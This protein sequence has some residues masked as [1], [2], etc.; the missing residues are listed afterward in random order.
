MLLFLSRCFVFG[1]RFCLV[2]C[3][4][5]SSAMPSKTH[6]VYLF[7]RHFVVL[8][9]VLLCS[10]KM[11]PLLI[12]QKEN[13]I[14]LG[15]TKHDLPAV[16]LSDFQNSRFGQEEV[17][18]VWWV[19]QV[20]C[21]KISFLKVL[22]N[23]PF[24]SVRIIL[25]EIYLQSSLSGVSHVFFLASLLGGDSRPAHKPCWKSALVIYMMFH[26]LFWAP[27]FHIVPDLW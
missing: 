20:F 6:C 13:H 10:A 9:E 22:A 18:R 2:C 21:L 15:F 5:L 24:D 7:G 8:R 4:C 19:S 14:I 23:C 26:H 16:C 25:P 3:S 11:D 17:S 12:W 27:F 1:M